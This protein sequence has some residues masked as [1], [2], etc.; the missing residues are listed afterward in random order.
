M[1]GAIGAAAGGA[2]GGRLLIETQ[3]GELRLAWCEAGEEGPLIDLVVTRSG[4]GQGGGGE[5]GDIFLGR[6][7]RSEK[8]LEAA[9][10]ELGLA[11]PG[12]LPLTDLA[13]AGSNEGTSLLVKV[14]RPAGPGK[15]VKLTCQLSKA[16]RAAV[17][18][19]AAAAQAPAL[20]APGLD[21]LAAF[22]ARR[23]EEV[24]VDDL[25]LYRRLKAEF[26]TA[27]PELAAGLRL[28]STGPPLFESAGIEE[29]IERLLEPEVT[30]P[31]GGFL[32]VEPVRSLTAIDVNSAGHSL[33][34][35]TQALARAVN[36]EAVMAIARELRLRQLAGLI[37]ID[38]LALRRPGDRKAVVAALKAA[39]A[40]D[41]ATTR[42][43]SM[44]PSGLVEMTRQ[45]RLRP[46]HE[47]L[48]RPAGD[49]GSGRVLRPESLAFEALR[50]TRAGLAKNPVGGFRLRASPA[51]VAALQDGAAAAARQALEARLGR[52][53]DL[54]AVPG[55]S[56]YQILRP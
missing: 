21:P 1:T 5:R 53:L 47:V 35:G 45:R 14:V 3:P 30:L 36:L 46:L 8:G 12:F 7:G 32:L 26:T 50:R 48:T 31:S 18:G 34:G 17:A 20:L 4:P 24:L 44:A 27:D 23:P 16:E 43:F 13:G 39:L 51:V 40:A 15:G 22:L 28:V 33:H 54:E 42:V 29:E 49:N 52:A 56:A 37:V 55:E 25:A 19:S 10:V 6:L 2:V 38:F 9:F 41:P 11:R